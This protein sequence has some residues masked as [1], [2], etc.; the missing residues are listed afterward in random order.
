[1]TDQTKRV[2]IKY[3]LVVVRIYFL[4]LVVAGLSDLGDRGF[5]IIRVTLGLAAIML[6]VYYVV[7]KDGP[8]E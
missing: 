7:S 6:F 3:M 1:M 2:V 4:A 8:L 5:P